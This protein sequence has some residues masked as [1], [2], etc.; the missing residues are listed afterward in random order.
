MIVGV[1]INVVYIMWD[2][3]FEKTSNPL[4]LLNNCAARF[5]LNKTERVGSRKNTKKELSVLSPNLLS[6]QLYT[7]FVQK[8]YSQF[9]PYVSKSL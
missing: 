5:S 1:K 3:V 2:G 7:F 6:K 9:N 8:I 4:I